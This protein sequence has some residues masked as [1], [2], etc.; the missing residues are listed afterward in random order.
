MAEFS[1]VIGSIGFIYTVMMSP[2]G[3]AIVEI[4]SVIVITVEFRRSKFIK[5]IKIIVNYSS[6]RSD[7]AD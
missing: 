4:G 2:K 1:S 6:S 7:Y 3:H 5:I